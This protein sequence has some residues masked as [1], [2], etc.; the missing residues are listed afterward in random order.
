MR[1][2]VMTPVASLGR[3]RG[4][5]RLTAVKRHSRH[6][7][8]GGASLASVLR[9]AVRGK[10]LSPLPKGGFFLWGLGVPPVA[11]PCGAP[12]GPVRSREFPPPARGAPL[13]IQARGGSPA[14]G[15]LLCPTPGSATPKGLPSGGPM[16]TTR[17]RRHPRK[18]KSYEAGWHPVAGG[19]PVSKR[20]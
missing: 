10:D 8:G 9:G 6:S 13:Y 14:T 1:W 17:L 7:G 18:R 11:F 2:L 3:L 12:R 19:A 20:M 16:G 15:A 5:T 4:V